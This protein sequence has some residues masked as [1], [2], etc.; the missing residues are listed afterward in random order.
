[1]FKRILLLL[2]ILLFFHVESIEVVF[3]YCARDTWT[4]ISL[5]QDVVYAS[6]HCVVFGSLFFCLDKWVLKKNYIQRILKRIG[7]PH[8]IIIVLRNLSVIL[9]VAAIV[10]EGRQLYIDIRDNVSGI[11]GIWGIHYV[12]NIFCISNLLAAERNKFSQRSP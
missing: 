4:Q 3:Y 11:W 10:F 2:A 1:M 7:L 12:F 5:V 9:C 8:D 6:M